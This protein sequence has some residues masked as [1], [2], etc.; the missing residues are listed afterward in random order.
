MKRAPCVAPLVFSGISTAARWP[1]FGLVERDREMRLEGIEPSTCGLKGR[2]SLA[3]RRL[4]LTTELQAQGLL[5]AHCR[6]PR[7]PCGSQTSIAA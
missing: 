6:R 2:C 1:R 3:P 7:G 4:P 5:S